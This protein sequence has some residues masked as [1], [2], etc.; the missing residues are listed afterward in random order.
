LELKNLTGLVKI[1]EKTTANQL[2]SYSALNRKGYSKIVQNLNATN[3]ALVSTTLPE[4]ER[5]NG[6]AL[7]KLLK[8]KYAGLDLV[9]RSAALDHFLDLKYTNLV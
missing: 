8:D 1:N 4:N 6:R 9:A 3:L 2:A 5:F 7:W